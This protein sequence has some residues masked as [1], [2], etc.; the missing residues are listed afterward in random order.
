MWQDVI[1]LCVPKAVGAE[2][3]LKRSSMMTTHPV[4]VIL[5]VTDGEKIK[6]TFNSYSF[7]S[8]IYLKLF[9]F[10]A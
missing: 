10:F 1:I 9:Q 7:Y 4:F 5:A 3:A 6:I 2:R 8:K